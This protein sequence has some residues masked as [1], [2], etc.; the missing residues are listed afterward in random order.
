MI[1]FLTRTEW[2]PARQAITTGHYL[3]RFP[4]PRSTPEVYEVSLPGIIGPVGYVS[5]GRP[6]AQRCRRSAPRPT[7]R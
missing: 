2:E 4:D 1:R 3:H 5:V 6:E 7:T